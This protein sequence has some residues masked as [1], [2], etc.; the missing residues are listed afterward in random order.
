MTYSLERKGTFNHY[1][2]NFQKELIQT[3]KKSTS[4][5]L[6][7]E[8][9]LELDDA[10]KS[11]AIGCGNEESP[12][13]VLHQMI[14]RFK[15]DIQENELTGGLRGFSCSNWD[16]PYNTEGRSWGEIKIPLVKIQEKVPMPKTLANRVITVGIS[17]G[18][19]RK[20]NVTEGSN[21]D[22]GRCCFVKEEKGRDAPFWMKQT[23]FDEKI[24]LM[25]KEEKQLR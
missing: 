14:F 6:K 24:K 1:I 4:V 3:I 18:I 8:Y 5:D 16:R 15:F 2:A 20:T 11:R 9:K 23:H 12:D 13:A 10:C 7:D 25:V 21:N 17:T 19:L 22:E